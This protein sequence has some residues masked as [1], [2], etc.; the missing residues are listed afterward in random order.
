[1]A[2][3]PFTIDVQDELIPDSEEHRLKIVVSVRL[4]VIHTRTIL[5]SSLAASPLAAFV[6]LSRRWLN[7]YAE[8]TPGGCGFYR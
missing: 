5:Y 6:A 4:P 7:R 3:S 2:T 1:M 8:V